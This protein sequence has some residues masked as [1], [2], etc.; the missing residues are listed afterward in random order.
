MAS[1]SPESTSATASAG[2]GLVTNDT[3]RPGSDRTPATFKTGLRHHRS[4][5]CD[6]VV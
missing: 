4:L 1:A 5:L 6:N 3:D 2:H